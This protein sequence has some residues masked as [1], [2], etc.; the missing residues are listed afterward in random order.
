MIG[1]A[2][3]SELIFTFYQ[4]SGTKASH[5]LLFIATKCLSPLVYHPVISVQNTEENTILSVYQ[6]LLVLIHA[7]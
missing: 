2:I 3:V 4:V 1:S 7:V 6:D 5:L